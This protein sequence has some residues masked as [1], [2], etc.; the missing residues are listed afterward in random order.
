[1]DWRMLINV[2]HLAGWLAFALVLGSWQVPFFLSANWQDVRAVW[3]EGSGFGDRFHYSNVAAVAGH[4]VGYPLE[5]LGCML[6]W[7]S[8]LA[9]FAWRQGRESLGKAGPY[10]GFV[11]TACVVAFPT[12]WL[13]ADSRPRY[14]MSL[15]PCMAVLI[16]LACQRAWETRESAGSQTIWKW[17]LGGNALAML[18]L[19]GLMTTAMVASDPRL[20]LLRQGTAF[21]LV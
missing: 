8:M 18:A 3:S 12:C 11:L 6:P 15:Y 9:V 1:R 21:T 16:G 7:S 17:F 5:V 4:F 2:R 20:E 10:A 13:P 14:F 19:A